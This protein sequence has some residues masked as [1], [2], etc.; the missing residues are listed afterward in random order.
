LSI[1]VKR[2]L[3][4]TNNLIKHNNFGRVGTIKLEQLDELLESLKAHWDYSSNNNISDVD[5]ALVLPLINKKSLIE[6]EL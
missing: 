3:S 1:N 4:V 6:Y 5:K 2:I